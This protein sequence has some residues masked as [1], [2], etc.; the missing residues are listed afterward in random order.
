MILNG[1]GF[2]YLIIIIKEKNIIYIYV[3]YFFTNVFKQ[4]FEYN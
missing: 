1:I 2:N 4:F 3:I